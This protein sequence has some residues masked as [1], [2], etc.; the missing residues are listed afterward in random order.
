M[1]PNPD[2]GTYDRLDALERR[3]RRTT[4]RLAALGVIVLIQALVI[5]YL[6]VP[7]GGPL[8]HPATLQAG[9]FEVID[10]DG[11]VRAVLTSDGGQTMLAMDDATGRGRILIRE[12]DS[13]FAALEMF[14]RGSNQ[15]S[16]MLM[17]GS[18][19]S[20]LELRDPRTRHYVNAQAGEGALGLSQLDDRDKE[21]P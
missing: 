5:A 11:T 2:R 14:D 1:Q 3:Q 6:A 4:R 15:K 10:R 8:K 12:N 19:R 17:A 9:R 13:G 7:F 18:K 16:V 20:V 21:L